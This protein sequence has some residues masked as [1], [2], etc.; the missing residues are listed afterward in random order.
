MKRIIVA[1][2]AVCLICATSGTL[3][4]QDTK[5]VYLDSQKILMESLAG[6]DAYKQLNTLKDQKA[7]E[8]EK[9]QNKLKTMADQLQAKSAT[10]TATAREDLEGKYDKELKDYNRSV[11]DAQDDLRRKEMEFLKPFSK[12]L[13]EIIKA[14]SEKNNIDLV[15]DK[16][17]PA[18]VYANPKID[19]TNQIITAFDKNNQEK[20][21][22]DKD[23]AEKE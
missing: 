15:L 18:I 21:V 14:Y 2:F 17:N 1:F 11:K 23:K 10:M 5:I 8:L 22:K 9:K 3:S 20:K 13:D 7:S 19:I 6:K 16:Q 4:A 12:D